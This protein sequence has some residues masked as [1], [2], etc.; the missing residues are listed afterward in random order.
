[1]QGSMVAA[2]GRVLQLLKL[3]MLPGESCSARTHR[4]SR[5]APPGSPIWRAACTEMYSETVG[6][7]RVEEVREEE[8]KVEEARA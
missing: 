1:M 6:F 5:C 7:L 3:K 4:W 2:L 8:A